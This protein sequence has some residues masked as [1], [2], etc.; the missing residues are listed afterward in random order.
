MRAVRPSTVAHRERQIRTFA[1][2]VALQGRDP[3]TITS[4]R[5]L[6]EIEVFKSGLRYLI[7]RSGGKA[8]INIYYL[9]GA[10]RAVARHHLHLE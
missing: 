6:V 9:A 4:L 10:L 7:A 2:A 8:T 3:D 1:S 5:D